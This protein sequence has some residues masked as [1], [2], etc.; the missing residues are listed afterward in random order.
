MEIIFVRFTV[1]FCQKQLSCTGMGDEN[2][3]T[4]LSI[5]EL[6]SSKPIVPY[7]R[8]GDMAVRSP[9]ISPERR[10]LDYCLIFIQKGKCRFIVDKEV[11]HPKAGDFCLIQPGSLVYLEGLT[12]TVTPF[13]H[14]DIFFQPDRE[15]SFPTRPGQIDLTP[16]LTYLQPRIN[17]YSGIHIPVRLKPSQRIRFVEVFLK[18]VEL[19]PKRDP[20][21]QWLIQQLGTELIV[22]ILTD[23]YQLHSRE[24]QRDLD[25]V[26]SY[27]SLHLQEHLSIE[28]LAERANM[29]SSWFSTEFKREY[30][31]SPHQFLL[32]MR[33]K[34]AEEL[35]QRTDF[36]QE[37]IANFCGFADIHHFSKTFKKRTGISPG[38]WR[39]HQK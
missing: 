13:L 12:D 28:T 6:T 30:G 36:T 38:V 31:V 7:F 20:S 26:T 19:W 14:F 24:T 11:Y 25:W 34:H 4:L 35:L 2:Q 29:S 27:F 22:A 10:L 32:E 8:E 9:W 39:K 5:T 33:I 17:D 21:S 23:H 3:V 37:E 16:Y 15:K 18:L 1:I